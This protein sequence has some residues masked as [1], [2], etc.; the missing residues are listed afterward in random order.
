MRYVMMLVSDDLA[1]ATDQEVIDDVAYMVAPYFNADT[2]TIERK[3]DY[4]PSTAPDQA[5]PEIECVHGIALSERCIRCPD[6]G[7]ISG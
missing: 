6:L 3:P 7:P 4:A 1:H 2:I 5:L